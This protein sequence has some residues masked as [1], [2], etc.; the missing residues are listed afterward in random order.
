MQGLLVP[1]EDF[2]VD[3]DDDVLLL[4]VF[5]CVVLFC[6]IPSLYPLE[7]S[8]T[9]PNGTKK[10]ISLDFSRCSLRQEQ[11]CLWLKSTDRPQR[12]CCNYLS[13]NEETDKP[14]SQTAETV[15]MEM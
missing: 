9:F 2:V 8:S 3:D 10:S 1:S 12:G 13:R 15:V 4:F 6:T 7:V 14:L 11:N 5:C